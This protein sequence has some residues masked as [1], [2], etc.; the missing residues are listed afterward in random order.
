VSNKMKNLR[1]A[2]QTIL[3]SSFFPSPGTTYPE[4]LY[5]TD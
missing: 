5:F 2:K 1:D 3:A 4:Q